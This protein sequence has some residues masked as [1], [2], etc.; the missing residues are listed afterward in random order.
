Q[1]YSLNVTKSVVFTK[2]ITASADIRASK[3]IRHS[4]GITDENTSVAPQFNASLI[5]EFFSLSS[6]YQTN[7]IDWPFLKILSGETIEATTWSS[8][9]STAPEGYP[10]LN[11]GFVQSKTKTT[12]E[13]LTFKQDTRS[14]SFSAGTSYTF[15]DADMTYNFS[16]IK[17]IDNIDGLEG[18][19]PSHF[20]NLSY[21]KG[22]M[23]NRLMFRFGYSGSLTDSK[24]ESLTGELTLKNDPKNPVQGL[25]ALTP[26]GGVPE[27]TQLA[28]ADALRDG[29]TVDPVLR[30]DDPTLQINL[31]QANTEI[32]LKL[33]EE[34]KIHTLRLFV[35]FD[36]AAN[37]T[38]QDEIDI[39]NAD[40]GWEIYTSPDNVVWTKNQFEITPRYFVND[41][42]FEMVIRGTPGDAPQALYFKVRNAIAPLNLVSFAVT[43]LQAIGTTT[44]KE[45]RTSEGDFTGQFFS[46][47]VN[48]AVS[49]RISLG[50]NINYDITTSGSKTDTD[51]E[52]LTTDT[53]NISQSLTF[54]WEIAKSLSFSSNFLTQRRSTRSSSTAG[55]NDDSGVNT[56]SAS[57]S[58]SPI[59]TINGS[60][61][62]NRS[63]NIRN[64]AID[65]KTDSANLAVFF[66]LY[67][68]VELGGGYTINDSENNANEK[69][70]TQ[71][72]NAN[73]RMRPYSTLQIQIL[74]ARFF[75]DVKTADDTN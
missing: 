25:F 40:F 68:N 55:L 15:L 56:F 51:A 60:L 23:E 24:S 44:E 50:Y 37:L 45:F 7:I 54:S 32:G 59:E 3:N 4:R 65:S 19:A 12:D 53:D 21:G 33:E 58:S 71:T 26:A 22:F 52:E 16:T 47:G 39:Q 10:T 62:L 5:C 11:L 30:P 36:A 14:D 29:N 70:T 41:N 6:S 48:F 67:R 13:A 17:T 34:A 57:V 43:E 69:D 9:F 73:L 74:A 1:N 46:G 49:D 27:S 8:S 18:R 35:A 72:V 20:L 63:Q 42:M 38:D 64:S 66:R 2:T 61:S 31:T 75:R 28:R